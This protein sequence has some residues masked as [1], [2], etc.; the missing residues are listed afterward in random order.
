MGQWTAERLNNV[1]LLK[2]NDFWLNGL[3]L[4]KFKRQVKSNP[5]STVLNP[6]KGLWAC[7]GGC[8]TRLRMKCLFVWF[9][10]RL[11]LPSTVAV[12]HLQNKQLFHKRAEKVSNITKTTKWARHFFAAFINCWFH[13]A[14]K[15]PHQMLAAAEHVE[16][17]AQ[18]CLFANLRTFPFL[19]S[20]GTQTP[21]PDLQFCSVLPPFPTH[22]YKKNYKK[23]N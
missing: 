7:R 8:G 21:T 22:P 16:V 13:R 5:F 14:N 6:N 10:A 18:V 15:E 3:F 17:S 4:I 20:S 1:C 12:V 23:W 19:V 9:N 11:V 2:E